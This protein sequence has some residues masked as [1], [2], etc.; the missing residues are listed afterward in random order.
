MPQRV[1]LLGQPAVQ[2]GILA[3]GRAPMAPS[4]RGSV[5]GWCVRPAGLVVCWPGPSDP[6]LASGEGDLDWYRSG[7]FSTLLPGH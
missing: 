6:G 3:G 2:S 7:V 1:L 4:Q 5:N